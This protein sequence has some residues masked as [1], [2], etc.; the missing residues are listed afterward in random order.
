MFCR[1]IYCEKANITAATALPLLYAAK[2]YLLTGLVAKSLYFI[3]KIAYLVFSA[4]EFVHLSHGALE[5]II[6]MDSLVGCNERQVY[7]SCVKWA[8]QQ[9]RESGNENP[10]DEDI[11]DKLG[12]VLYKIR[13]PTM[14][15][16]IFAEL[17]AHSAVLSAEEKHD[18]YVYMILRTKLKTLKFVTERRTDDAVS[19]FNKTGVRHSCGPTD[20]VSIK[21][22]VDIVLTG[23]G[24][25]GGIGASSHDVTLQ[26]LKGSHTLSKTET[27]MV[28][29][30]SLKP[31]KIELEK[32]VHVHANTLYTVAAVMKGPKTW[33]GED[34]KS[35]CDFPKSGRITFSEY[36]KYDNGTNVRYGQIP[37]LF[38]CMQ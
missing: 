36:Q 24:L 20:A 1:Y 8:R 18:V 34:G 29:D 10:S 37:Q 26:V 3:S 2:K 22:T 32:P 31:I 17:T 15:Q 4:E 9:L 25:Y 5:D 11:R 38:Y 35:A 27:K 21:A 13:F 28:S 12:N 14:T 16:K 6:S 23:V 7:E 30:G 33:S 19:R